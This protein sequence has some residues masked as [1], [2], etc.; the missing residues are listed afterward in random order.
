MWFHFLERFIYL[1]G[2]FRETFHLVVHSP[3]E[4]SSLGL[5]AR[6]L[7]LPVG[8]RAK[9]S[10][11]LPLLSQAA[12]QGARSEVEQPGL[13]LEARMNHCPI[14]PLLILFLILERCGVVFGVS[15]LLFCTSLET[16]PH[17]FFKYCLSAHLFAFPVA[18]FSS[19]GHSFLRAF[20]CLL[21]F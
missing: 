7:S 13:E 8:G 16:F 2:S 9:H 4:H 3:N 6:D 15:R 14:V 12:E 20:Q 21:H 11:Q 5:G 1:K 17:Y 10:G 18:L 19:L